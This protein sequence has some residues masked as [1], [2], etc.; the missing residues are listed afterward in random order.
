M[1]DSVRIEADEDGFHLILDGDMSAVIEKWLHTDGGYRLN[2]RLSQTAAAELVREVQPI[3]EWWAEGQAVRAE[4]SSVRV[5]LLEDD[6]DD[7]PDHPNPELLA[8]GA[9]LARKAT[10]ENP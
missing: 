10:R 2:L 5:A 8:E 9:D 6:E 4:M 7:D 1:I 3:R